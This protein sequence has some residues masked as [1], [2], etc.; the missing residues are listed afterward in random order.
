MIYL[1]DINILF[2]Y[3]KII[4]NREE[5]KKAKMANQNGASLRCVRPGS[6]FYARF[7][8]LPDLFSGER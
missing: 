2:T 4:A 7:W 3:G 8:A 6:R 5:P 1:L